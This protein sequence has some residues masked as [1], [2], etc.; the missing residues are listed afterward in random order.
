MR[1]AVLVLLASMMVACGSKPSTLEELNSR[2]VT[3]PGGR[4]VQ[5]EVVATPQ[6]MARGLMYRSSIAPDRGMLFIHER[7]GYNSYWMYQCLISLDLIW[8]DGD[9]RIVELVPNAPP[10]KT[11]ETSQC[12]NYGGHEQS[13]FVLELGGGMAAKY[14]LKLGDRLDF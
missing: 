5:A 1:A 12:P 13:R 3:L 2:V 8:M 9:H 14:G 4:Q 11:E 10:C 7:P 6:E